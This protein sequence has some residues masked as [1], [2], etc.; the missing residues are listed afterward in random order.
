MRRKFTKLGLSA[1]LSVMLISM[2]GLLSCPAE[3]PQALLILDAMAMTQQQQC[4]IRP[5]GGAQ[6]IRPF[7]V[8]DLAITNSYWL[9]PRFKNMMPTLAEITG[10]GPSSGAPTETNYLSIY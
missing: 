4:T 3:Q 1:L 10:E 7:G 5:G 2:T 9:F 8:L 6:I